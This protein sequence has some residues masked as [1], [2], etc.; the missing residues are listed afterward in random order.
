MKKL[1]H[2]ALYMDKEVWKKDLFMRMSILNLE[3]IFATLSVV[4]YHQN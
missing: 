1:F 4:M 2:R 3:R